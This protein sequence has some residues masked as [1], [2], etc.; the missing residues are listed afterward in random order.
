MLKKLVTVSREKTEYDKNDE[1]T[2]I[3]STLQWNDAVANCHLGKRLRTFF[4]SKDDAIPFCKTCILQEQNKKFIPSFFILLYLN[5]CNQ[6]ISFMNKV[7]LPIQKT[8]KHINARFNFNFSN[9]IIYLSMGNNICNHTIQ[10][11]LTYPSVIAN[12]SIDLNASSVTAKKWCYQINAEQ[13]N[14]SFKWKSG[15][16]I[17]T[18]RSNK[19]W[20][21][22]RPR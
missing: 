5:T 17:N 15:Y 13:V 16:N 22:E 20:I 10:S 19:E 9:C 18:K 3:A 7:A 1:L 6:K 14:V 8:T 21:P 12:N 2:L 11:A 4:Y